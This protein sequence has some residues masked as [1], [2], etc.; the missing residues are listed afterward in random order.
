MKNIVNKLPD[1]RE[2]I[3]EYKDTA[4][5]QKFENLVENAPNNVIKFGDCMVV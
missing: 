4:L 3:E 2:K 5:E 1:M